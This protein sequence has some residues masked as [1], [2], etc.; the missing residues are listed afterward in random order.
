VSY[1]VVGARWLAIPIAAIVGFLPGLFAGP[2]LDAGVFT[3]VG[4]QITN[5]DVPYVDAWDHK[6][7]GIHLVHALA[8]ALPGTEAWTWTWTLS[9]VAT[10]ATSVIVVRIVA[11]YV[12]GASATAAGTACALGLSHFVLSL[13]GGMSESFAVLPAT[14]ALAVVL[15]DT[16]SSARCLLAGVLVGLAVITSPQL[17]PAGAACLAVLLVRGGVAALTAYVIGG[18][19]SGLV[20]VG[21]L[22]GLGAW[23][24]FLDAVIHYNAAYRQADGPAFALVPW[25]TLTLIFLL[26]PALAGALAY[27]RV[28]PAARTVIVASVTWILASVMLTAVQGRLY[29]HYALGLAIPL[30]LLA[31]IGIDDALNRLCGTVVRLVGALVLAALVLLSLVVGAA[32]GRMEMAMIEALN[33]RAS[34]VA[35]WAEREGLAGEAMLVWGN[36]PQAYAFN[37]SEP[38]LRYGFLYPLT[39]PGYVTEERVAAAFADLEAAPPTLVIDAGSSAPSAPGFLPLLIDRPVATDGR[40]VDLLDPLRDFVAN[41]YEL[42]DT[43]KGWPVYRLTAEVNE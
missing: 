29:G 41:Q 28:D 17:L 36:A 11:R 27:R 20:V 13:G 8:N 12:R 30:S 3:L 15:R 14:T 21:A 25:A 9:V 43:V 39:T 16:R 31:A 5:G 22:V 18:A 10:V 19:L 4:W 37:G 6:P 24:A 42:V 35:A 33:A 26:F 23:P 34:A 2:S 7:P 38:T 1:L 40:D 32:G